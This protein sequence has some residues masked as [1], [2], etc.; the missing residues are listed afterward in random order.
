MKKVK[1][2][3][4]VFVSILLTIKIA[5]YF[6]M[7]QNDQSSIMDCIRYKSL[8][9]YLILPTFIVFLYKDIQLKKGV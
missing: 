5:Q 1:I 9:E 6:F 3:L 2:S 7:W 8:L 4:L